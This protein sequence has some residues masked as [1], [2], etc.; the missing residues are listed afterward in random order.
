MAYLLLLGNTNQYTFANT[1]IA[2]N[3][4]S[5]TLFDKELDK[6]FVIH[7]PQ[8][9]EQLRENREW[10]NHIQSVGIDIYEIQEK[11]IELVS[12]GE[13]ATK[14]FVHYIEFLFNGTG[15]DQSDNWLVDL[16]NG[17][18]IQKNLLSITSYILD[19]KHQY[20]VNISVLSQLTSERG[21]LD[22]SIM[23][24]CYEPAPDSTLMD[25]FAYL[26]LSE[27]V[28]YKKI[29]ERQRQSFVSIGKEFADD[30]FFKENL[31]HSVKLKLE[32]DKK[33]DNTIYRIATTSI[34]SSVEE[35]ITILAQ[36]IKNVD[37]KTLGGKI[38]TIREKIEE[39]APQHFDFD[40]FNKFND[41]MLYLRN[42]TTHKGKL[43]TD[44][45]RFKAELALNMSFPFLDFYA[46][47]INPIL[48]NTTPDL[49]L[50]SK[51]IS[52]ITTD[53]LN[54]K[55]TFYFGLDGDNTGSI[56]EGLFLS[57]GSNE[58]GFRNMSK[59]VTNAIKKIAKKIRA[60]NGKIIF[61]AG[62][63]LL[64]KG[65]FDYK[66]LE[67]MKEI[68][69]KETNGQTCSISFGSTLHETY[70]AMKIAK[71][72]PGK[73]TIMGIELLKSE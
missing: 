57:S 69:H 14:K 5:K 21:F 32:G 46:D 73:N 3:E 31:I 33:R 52:Q 20:M 8:S 17:T 24:Q 12:G 37:Q 6:I 49:N 43:L 60:A 71:A 68:Y 42:S 9:S 18:S 30:I 34:S 53:E 64:F 63:D 11:V 67:D 35:L 27:M 29:I 48:S 23:K 25:G 28:R 51:Q 58:N 7:S 2:A 54:S 19:I 62:D 15:I 22:A 10:V 55:K 70:L 39:E 4:E 41:F 36:K 16:T 59:N 50:K 47:I 26:D 72:H 61:D 65:S 45:E 1:I 56:L 38:H 44:L 40:F 13:D 66:D